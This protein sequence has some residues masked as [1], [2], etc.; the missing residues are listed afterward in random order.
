M[1]SGEPEEQ[2]VQERKELNIAFEPS[3]L[4]VHV[5]LEDLSLWRWHL[6]V[7]VN[8]LCCVVVIVY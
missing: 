4:A 1:L 3:T 2:G 6:C 7:L 5:C 8:V